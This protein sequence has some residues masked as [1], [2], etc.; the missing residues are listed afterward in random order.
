MWGYYVL[1]GDPDSPLTLGRNDMKPRYVNDLE[2]NHVVKVCPAI[3]P[4]I[5]AQ[6]QSKPIS[7]RRSRVDLD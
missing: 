1:G 7:W 3:T 5:V 2:C 6:Q 4:R